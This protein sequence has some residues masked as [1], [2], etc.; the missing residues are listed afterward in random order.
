VLDPK[1]MCNPIDLDKMLMDVS[2]WRRSFSKDPISQDGL[3]FIQRCLD[4]DP[5]RRLTAWE[6]MQHA[7]MNEPQ[8]HKAL[9]VK[10]EL[11]STQP[12]KTRQLVY[13]VIVDLPPMVVSPQSTEMM[14]R[15]GIVAVPGEPLAHTENRESF[16]DTSPYFDMS[17]KE[18]LRVSKA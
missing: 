5:G 4:P 2:L 7:W 16:D 6:A 10:R 9:F 3:D 17:G 15:V 13:P 8:H 14:A 18:C 11:E 12:W 1:R